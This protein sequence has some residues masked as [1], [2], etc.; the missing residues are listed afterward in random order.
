MGKDVVDVVDVVDEVD[1]V[2]AD[3]MV[4]A[5]VDVEDVEIIRTCE[6]KPS[7]L[8]TGAGLIIIQ[9]STFRTMC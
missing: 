3:A 8:Q 6:P 5:E 1:V 9:A 4:V 2:D 7:R